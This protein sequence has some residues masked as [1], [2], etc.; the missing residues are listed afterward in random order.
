MTTKEMTDAEAYDSPNR[1]IVASDGETIGA[2]GQ[3]YSDDRTQRPEWATVASA[4]FEG[5]RF[6]PLAGASSDGDN[7]RARVTMTQVQGAPSVEPN[8]HLSEQEQALLLEYYGIPLADDGLT[9]TPGQPGGGE[10]MSGA[11]VRSN[12][13]ADRLTPVVGSV[14]TTKWTGAGD[15]DEPAVEKTV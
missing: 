1:T 12:E 11:K 15:P 14:R 2:V 8:G 6:V 3:I 9:P 10:F 5:T 4:A 13:A 7:I